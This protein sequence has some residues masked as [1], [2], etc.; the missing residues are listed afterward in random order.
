MTSK[1]IKSWLKL[2]VAIALMQV[3]L[4][5]QQAAANESKCAPKNTC[6]KAAKGGIAGGKVVGS[7]A[8]A[9]AGTNINQGSDL[10]GG[11]SGATAQIACKVA[12]DCGK[13][14]KD[15]KPNS[16]G[17]T[18]RDCDDIKAK[19][20]GAAGECKQA[21]GAAAD[22]QK[23][24]SASGAG[25]G[26][27]DAMMGALMGAA[28]GA[29]M[30]MLMNKK[31][32]DDKPPQQIPHNGALQ[33]NGTIDCS[34]P[35]AFMF[36][37]CNSF[38]ENR[39]KNILDD[40]TCQQF[41]NR[42][43]GGGAAAGGNATL[44][45]QPATPP[46][47]VFGVDPSTLMGQ[48]GEGVGSQYCKGVMAWNYCKTSGR[49]LCPS[50][51]AIAKNQSPACAQNPALC[52]AQNSASEIEKAK[53]TCPTDP[54]FADPAFAGGGAGGPPA[55]AGG[56][57]MPALVL[58]QSVGAPEGGGAASAHSASNSSS[59]SAGAGGSMN[60]QGAASA[61]A[62]AGGSGDGQ[63]A[64]EGDANGAS[65]GS[66]GGSAGGGVALNYGTQSA[67]GGRELA[68][69]GGGNRGPASDVE[70][71][72]GPSLFNTSTQVIRRRCQAGKLNNCP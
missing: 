37:D 14:E 43:C 44:L 67:A 60:G 1:N 59:G 70:S 50:C 57:G 61:A 40:P 21:M 24:Q 25:G 5:P 71:Q 51:L 33:A 53:Q 46:G 6:D 36:R 20:A 47:V 4:L 56:G 30:A 17:C 19:V 55:V 2:F 65:A 52:M 35:D 54:A 64:R 16:N 42:F 28:L 9:K 45:A 68:Q 38:M 41:S 66:Q 18:Q 48:Q 10:L 15:C 72:Y 23:T 62:E 39:C 8:G 3:P 34:K 58:P 13:A 32:E 69:A 31:K 11:A 12:D 63:A 49:E 26:G 7:T 22:S 29:G 27:G